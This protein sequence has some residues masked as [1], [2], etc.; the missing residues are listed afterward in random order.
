MGTVVNGIVRS[1]S[2]GKSNPRVRK[3]MALVK[4]WK[5]ACSRSGIRG[6]CADTYSAVST[7]S[8]SATNGRIPVSK[9]IHGMASHK[10]RCFSTRN[11]QCTSSARFPVRRCMSMR[12]LGQ[13]IND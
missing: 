5:L 2:L 1:L 13:S 10:S 6:A 11:A 3:H 7:L 8:Q 4:T 12:S 9:T